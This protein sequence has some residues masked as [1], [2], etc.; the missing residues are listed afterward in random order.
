M[1]TVLSIRTREIT[2]GK[3]SPLG[4]TQGAGP[5]DA[6]AA[7]A[8]FMGTGSTSNSSSSSSAQ[9]AQDAADGTNARLKRQTEASE[10]IVADTAGKGAAS[11]LPTA[12]DQGLITMTFYQVGDPKNHSCIN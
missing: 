3:A 4:R 5:V 10:T 6:A 8:V 9:T 7:V 11:G 1:L 2:S 12:S